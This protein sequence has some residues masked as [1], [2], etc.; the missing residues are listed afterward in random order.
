M[1]TVTK[2][3]P[4]GLRHGRDRNVAGGRGIAVLLVLACLAILAPFTASFNYQARVD[5]QSAV[6]VRD[7][8][9]ARNIQR[10][11]MQLSLLLFEIQRMV[12]NQ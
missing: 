11:A 5:W 12:F 3:T 2:P 7:E 9:A 10:G 4:D 6:N 1:T 8:V